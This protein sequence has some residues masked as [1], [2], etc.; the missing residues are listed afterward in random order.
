MR[1]TPMTEEHQ[2]IDTHVG[3]RLR[4]LRKVRGLSQERL[5]EAGSVT[6][7]QVQKYERGANRVSASMLLTF[8]RALDVG[9]ESF[10]EGL[11]DFPIQEDAGA[12]Q[13]REFG[14]TLEGREVLQAASGLP[15]PV[16]RSFI[17]VMRAC[18]TDED[19]GWLERN[20]GRLEQGA[21]RV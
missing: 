7:Q 18:A 13:A 6:F 8:A 1:R 10:F 14:E 12:R 17:V 20:P 11:P 2:T 4:L 15:R 16:L 9:V 19:D 3:R 21:A 5:A